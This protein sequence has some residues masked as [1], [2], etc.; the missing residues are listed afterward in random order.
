MISRVK[1]R[2]YANIALIK[3]WGKR[4]S[5]RNIPATPSISLALDSLLTETEVTRIENSPD[6]IIINNSPADEKTCDRIREYLDFWRSQ[7]L[8]SGYFSISSF[9]NF[10]TGAGL[11]SSASGFAALATA[12][13]GFSK[14]KVSQM[15]L[16]RLARYGSGSAARSIP[17]GIAILRPG[18]NPASCGFLAKDKIP[19]GMVI[20][21]VEAGEKKTGSREGMEL[22]RSTSPYFRA[23]V[24]QCSHDFRRMI[25]AILKSDFTVMGTI[26]EQNAFAMHACMIATR[27][28]L[29]YWSSA[30]VELIKSSQEFRSGGLETYITIDAGPNVAFLC[31]LDDLE[32]VARE[33]GKLDGVKSVIANRPAGPAEIVECE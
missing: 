13:S 8:L 24:N 11:A 23:W 2:A 18:K 20:A 3:Y 27:P 1:A 25:P 19:W 12:L 33:V 17:G 29:L 15:K 31:K 4:K 32:V 22:S 9:N 10:P 6:K 21:I 16:S 26:A 28:S 7:K 14:R 30:T 5:E